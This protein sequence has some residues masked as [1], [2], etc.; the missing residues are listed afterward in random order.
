M[1]VD[2]K[3]SS[4][5]NQWDMFG[6]SP[7]CWKRVDIS[8]IFSTSAIKFKIKA[9]KLPKIQNLYFLTR[10]IKEGFKRF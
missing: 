4:L 1:L 8:S 9:D 7:Y 5:D 2:L 6:F 10:E 3:E